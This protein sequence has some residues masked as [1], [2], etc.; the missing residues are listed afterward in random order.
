MA[1]EALG[2]KEGLELA[3]ARE[4]GAEHLMRL[5]LVPASAWIHGTHA[6][7]RR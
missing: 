5:A 1:F 3:V 7:D 4:V 6:V 2:E